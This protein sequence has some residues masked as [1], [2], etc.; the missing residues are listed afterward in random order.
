MHQVEAMLLHCALAG[1]AD[2]LCSLS[3]RCL[4]QIFCTMSHL[5]VLNVQPVGGNTA[6]EKMPSSRCRMLAAMRMQ[7][8]IQGKVCY[9]SPAHSS[10]STSEPRAGNPA[11]LL[12]PPLPFKAVC[13][14]VRTCQDS[15]SRPQREL[16]RS[17]VWR[18]QQQGPFLV[19]QQALPCEG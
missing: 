12:R 1:L 18:G 14:R 11:Y 9:T 5:D 8:V 16:R 15:L 17:V 10:H 7:G 2:S 13:M 6:R 3:I 19:Q 4:Q